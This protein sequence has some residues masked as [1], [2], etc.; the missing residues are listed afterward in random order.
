MSTPFESARRVDILGLMQKPLPG[1]AG[2]AVNRRLQKR[3]NAG[4]EPRGLNF[5]PLEPRAGFT[6]SGEGLLK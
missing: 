1:S 4:Q 6:P 3:G 2:G 5:T